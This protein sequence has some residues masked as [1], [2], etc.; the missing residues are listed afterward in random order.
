MYEDR[1]S[2]FLVCVFLQVDARLLECE[3]AAGTTA[4]RSHDP[5]GAETD[6]I[7]DDFSATLLTEAGK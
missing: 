7:R 5:G 6:M 4:V 3:T 1:I 2:N